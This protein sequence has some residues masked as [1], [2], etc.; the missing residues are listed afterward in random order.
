VSAIFAGLG[1]MLAVSQ[2]PLRL[3]IAPWVGGDLQTTSTAAAKYRLEITGTPHAVVR[4]Q[5]VG[6]ATGWLAAFCT[7]KY[8]SPQRVV[9]VLPA[10]G[11]AIFQFELIRESE[12]APKDSGAVITGA[13]GVS[14][15]VPTA[16]R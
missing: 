12:T 8:C 5:A 14:V 9:D 1:M 15:T 16:H 7:P 6:V 13:D 11:V 10:S 2:P 3:S 4:L